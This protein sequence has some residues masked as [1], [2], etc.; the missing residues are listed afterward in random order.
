MTPLIPRKVLFGNPDKANPKIS[1]DGRMIAYLAPEEGV[2]N[3]WIRTVGGNDDRAVTHDR[4][5]GIQSYFWQPGSAHILYL[6]DVGGNENYRIY[7]TAIATQKTRD[8]TPFDDVRA[9]IV[10]VDA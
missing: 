4:V 6:Q 8:L 10:A 9:S 3:V 5:R 7:Q 2:L 1:P